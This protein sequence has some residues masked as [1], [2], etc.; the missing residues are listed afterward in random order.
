MKYV[1]LTTKHHEGF[2]LWDSKVT[3]YKATN[4]PY[5]RDLIAPFV[6]A[7]RAEGLK[8]GF[9][10][11]LI[12]WHHPDFPIDMHHPQRNHPDAAALNAGPRHAP[13]RRLHARAGARAADRLR[14]DRHHLVRLQLSAAAP[15]RTCP[16]RAA[17][18]GRA[19][20][21]L[22]LV[23]ELQP[24]IIV[25]NRLDLLDERGYLPDITTPEQYTPR[26]GAAGSTAR[27]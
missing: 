27:R 4:T 20:E 10:Y 11:S 6:E 14:Q 9:Y 19:S 16:A 1:V 3:D 8:I 22:T 23:R 21:L 18:T 2:C 25:N 5:G 12:D 13:L 17:T 7:F 26:A 24:D 15:T